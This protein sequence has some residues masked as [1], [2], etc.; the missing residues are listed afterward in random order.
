MRLS[1]LPSSSVARRPVTGSH[2]AA[3]AGTT[4]VGVDLT[5]VVPAVTILVITVIVGM[6]P[7]DAISVVA[8]AATLRLNTVAPETTLGE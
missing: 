5:G 1:S 6:I 4:A 2:V 3:R 7:A 8:S